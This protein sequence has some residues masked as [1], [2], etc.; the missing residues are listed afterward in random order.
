MWR[1]WRSLFKKLVSDSQPSLYLWRCITKSQ[2]SA[3]NNLR[4]KD[5][6]KSPKTCWDFLVCEL[7]IDFSHPCF[8]PA[9]NQQVEVGLGYPWCWFCGSSF[10]VTENLE[11][12]HLSDRQSWSWASQL[13]VYKYLTKKK[14]GLISCKLGFHQMTYLSLTYHP[15]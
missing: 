5:T 7:Q 12:S 1:L 11:F 8:G 9:Y 15:S 3:T 2:A 6:L 14:P 10:R 13:K 4:I